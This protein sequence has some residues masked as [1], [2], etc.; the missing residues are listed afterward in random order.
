MKERLITLAFAAGALF[1][2]YALFVPKPAPE[3]K[4]AALPVSTETK[5]EGYQALWRWLE[6]QQIPVVSLRERYDRLSRNAPTATGNVLLA[7]LPQQL[8]A[9]VDEM[10][11]LDTWIERGNTLVVMAALDDTPKWA[12]VADETFERTL[13]R[14]TRM[15]FSSGAE[16]DSSNSATDDEDND[17]ADDSAEAEKAADDVDSDSGSEEDNSSGSDQNQAETESIVQQAF[18]KLLQPERSSIEPHG[19]HP[20]LQEI[21]TISALSEF[22]AS[23]WR[24]SSLDHKAILVLGTRTDDDVDAPDTKAVL[25]LK[26]QGAGQI[27]ICAFA[28]PFNNQLLGETDNAQLFA[29]ILAWSRAAHG[30][31]LF[32]DMHQGLVSYYDAKAFFGDPRLHRTLLWILLLWLV[33]VMG[34]Q[35]FRPQLDQWQPMDVTTFIKVTGSFFAGSLT[36]A[37]T[38]QR[39]FENFFN[40]IRRRVALPEDGQPVWEWLTTQASIANQELHDLQQLY[41]ST[42]RGKRVDLIHLQNRLNSLMRHLT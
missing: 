25:W 37:N 13:E 7:T 14:L 18:E 28:T 41:A 3:D 10:E 19:A 27:I 32:D 21:Q 6:R 11:S 20:L 2:F 1:L 17:E 39:L 26:R 9:R 40:R 38:G 22:P 35:R 24:A 4:A 30:A 23:R 33:F 16:T 31:V 34:W 42:Q 12:L 8:P 15:E 29:N 5:A 36:T